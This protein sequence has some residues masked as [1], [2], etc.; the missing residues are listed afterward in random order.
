MYT[1]FLFKYKEA[2][3]KLNKGVTPAKAGVQKFLKKLDSRFRGNDN[4]GFSQFALK[5]SVLLINKR[6]IQRKHNPSWPT[7][8]ESFRHVFLSLLIDT[9]YM[10]FY[11]NNYNDLT[12]S[13]YMLSYMIDNALQLLKMKQ[14]SILDKYGGIN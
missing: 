12:Y 4:P 9:T 8:S 2:T 11:N 13:E 10:R 6:A 1:I 3:A 5:K 7:S 14:S